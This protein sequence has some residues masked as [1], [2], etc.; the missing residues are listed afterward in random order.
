MS[1][2][3]KQVQRVNPV[4]ALETA[5]QSARS[6]N[7]VLLIPAV[8]DRYIKNYEMATGNPD[9]A[10]KYE[11]DKFAFIEKVNANPELMNC[12]PLSIMASFMKLATYGVH[13]DKIYLQ[14][15][16]AKQKD[17]TYKQFMKV[18]LDPF[19]KKEVLERM[20]TIKRVEDPQLVFNEDEF[21]VDPRA[22]R[23]TV[24]KSKFPLPKPSEATVK[25]VY[26]TVVFADDRERDYWLSLEEL[27]IRRSKSK[28]NG[29]GELWGTHYG[30]AAK[31]SVINYLY[32]SE[33]KAPETNKL[34][35]K[36]EDAVEIDHEEETTQTVET[37]PATP[38][39]GDG[40]MPN[41]NEQT[42]EVYEPAQ[43]VKKKEEP[44]DFM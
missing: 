25:A 26:V 35:P 3:N 28:M 7:E 36:Y 1:T 2:E 16:G 44:S 11:R 19:G 15:Q 9:G 13:P 32:K 34:F 6:T 33:Y 22:K 14:P 12:D 18:S 31:K 23:V 29:G 38:V 17:N 30:E 4:K 39:T 37:I 24:H 41:V 10:A 21:E 42:G 40:F 43:V 5:I 20:S 8:K 27:K